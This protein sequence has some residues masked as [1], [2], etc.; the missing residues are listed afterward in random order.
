MP[1]TKELIES[2]FQLFFP[3]VCAGCGSDLLADKQFLCLRC[4]HEL[5]LTHFHLHAANPVEKIFWGRVPIVAACAHFYFAK[6]SALQQVMHQF[7]Y[8]GQR[9]IGEYFGRMMGEAMFHSGRFDTVDALIPLP[10]YASREKRRGYNQAA[11]ICEGIAGIMKL[12]L[13]TNAVMRTHATETQTHKN[14]INRWQ[15]MIGRFQLSRG[16]ILENKHLLLVDDIITTG[17]TLDACA[18]ELLQAPGV[19]VSVAALA[20]TEASG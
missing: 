5:P 3:H 19:Q 17:A 11:V 20:W 1:K 2:I 14:R 18:N 8:N 9:E 6:H 15:N 7:K 16:D 13:L 12:P 4:L 10:L